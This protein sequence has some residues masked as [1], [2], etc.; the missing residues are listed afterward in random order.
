MEMPMEMPIGTAHRTRGA[1]LRLRSAPHLVINPP[2][3]GKIPRARNGVRV[4]RVRRDVPGCA[5]A[6]QHRDLFDSLPAD[7]A[8]LIAPRRS[9]L[10]WS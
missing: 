2:I 7:A 5:R 4:W 6:R 3:D 10:A 9:A 8:I 1:E